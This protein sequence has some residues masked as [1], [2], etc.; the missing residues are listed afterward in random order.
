MK[1]DTIYRQDVIDTLERICFSHWFKCR[2]YDR[3]DVREYKII[4]KNK[5]LEEI[6]ALPSAQPDEDARHTEKEQAY[7][8]GW[9][10]GQKAL[11]KEIF[12]EY[13]LIP[14]M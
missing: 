12:N 11:R 8:D 6:E 9:A 7:M 5:A 10:D 2:E 4:S 13:G 3:D 14:K 1:E